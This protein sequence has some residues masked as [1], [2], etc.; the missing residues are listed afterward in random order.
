MAKPK[1]KPKQGDIYA[2]VSQ[3]TRKAMLRATINDAY[4]AVL[5]VPDGP[6]WREQV[7]ALVEDHTPAFV[8]FGG[9]E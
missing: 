4:K 3:M 2:H 7:N 5:K 9:L 6:E 1:P 8:R